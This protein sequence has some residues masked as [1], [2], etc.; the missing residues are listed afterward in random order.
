VTLD[1]EECWTR[2]NDSTH[3]VLATVHPERGV[4]AVPVV[5]AV[6]G[7]V[8][9]V[10]VDTVKPKRHLRLA[11]LENLR[12]DSRCVL[13]VDCYTDDWSKLWWVRVHATAELAASP[14]AWIDALATRFPAYRQAGA[15]AGVVVLHPLAVTGWAAQ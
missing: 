5:F 3:G 4:D 9:V 10:P 13:L 7:G 12:R 8:I 1:I 2:L 6:A 15:V 11:R 14:V